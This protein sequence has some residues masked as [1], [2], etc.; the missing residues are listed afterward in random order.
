MFAPTKVTRERPISER[1][2][3]ILSLPNALPPITAPSPVLDQGPTAASAAASGSTSSLSPLALP[4]LSLGCS[5][6]ERW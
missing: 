5:K 2:A 6:L 4:F 1:M 3:L